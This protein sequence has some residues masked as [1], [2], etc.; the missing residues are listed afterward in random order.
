MRYDICTDNFR[1]LRNICKIFHCSNYFFCCCSSQP[2][3]HSFRQ[4]L[5]P[6]RWYLRILCFSIICLPTN[7]LFFWINGV[8]QIYF[9][10]KWIQICGR[11]FHSCLFLFRIFFYRLLPHHIDCIIF[12]QFLLTNYQFVLCLNYQLCTFF[13]VCSPY[14][15]FIFCF[16]S[17]SLFFFSFQIY[18]AFLFRRSNRHIIGSYHNFSYA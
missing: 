12:K 6:Y 5:T 10:C 3:A 16:F 13:K 18:Q 4:S 15:C 9:L 7:S 11:I 8:G 14:F 2:P 1:Y 17:F